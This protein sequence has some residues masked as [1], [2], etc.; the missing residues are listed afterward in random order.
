MSLVE[1]TIAYQMTIHR[2]GIKRQVSQGVLEGLIPGERELIKKK[3]LSASKRIIESKEYDAIVSLDGHTSRWL[4]EHS[5]P[6]ILK[7]GVYCL[8][9]VICGEVDTYIEEYKR[10]RQDEIVPLFIEAYETQAYAARDMLGSALFSSLEYPTVEKMRNLF[11]VDTSYLT[12]DVPSSLKYVSEE[13]FKREQEK[14]EQQWQEAAEAINQLLIAECAELVSGLQSALT[15]LNDGTLKR[16]RDANFV[17]LDTWAELFLRARNVTDNAELEGVVREIRQTLQG[18]THDSL[19][20]NS[21]NIREYLGVA[22]QEIQ[23]ELKGM[24]EEVDERMI[25]F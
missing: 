9:V 5:V 12:F 7:K 25:S 18:V 17:N 16:F 21:G 8:P 19:K 15:G 20:Y 4:G 1:N 24:M 3:M 6:S 2:W 10:K 13:L 11:S 14:V 23:V 22:M